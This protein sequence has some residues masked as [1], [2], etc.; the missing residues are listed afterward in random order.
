MKLPRHR[1]RVRVEMTPL[2]DIIFLVLVLFIYA[3][4]TMT[5]DRGRKLNL[6]ESSVAAPV[7]T[8]GP[9]LYLSSDGAM[10]L[11]KRPVSADE[12]PQI[13]QGLMAESGP[14][15]TVRV[16]ADARLDYQTLYRALDLLE[17]AGVSDIALQ[18]APAASGSSGI[19]PGSGA[20]APADEKS[21][22]EISQ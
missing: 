22:R 7:R 11:D 8:E 5:P 16:F 17:Q 20:A 14:S 9:G 19:Q 1:Q 18:A 15:L 3:M 13:L 12:L 2:L 21:N 4:L 6:P 10:F